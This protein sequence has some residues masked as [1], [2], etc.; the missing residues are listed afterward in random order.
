MNKN[1]PKVP[2]LTYNLALALNQQ[3]KMAESQT[4]L[5]HL[6][7]ENQWLSSKTP[8]SEYKQGD[9]KEPKPQ[10]SPSI[11]EEK[12]ALR[13]RIHLTQGLMYAAHLQFTNAIHA[14][15]KVS[16]EG[17]LSDQ[18]LFQYALASIQTGEFAI[19]IQALHTLTNKHTFNPRVYESYFAVGYLFEQMHKNTNAY[20]AYIK[21]SQYYAETTHTLE[22]ALAQSMD[23]YLQPLLTRKQP[24]NP[25]I[26]HLFAKESFQLNLHYIEELIALKQS[27]SLWAKKIDQFEGMIEARKIARN[28][29]I[30]H[31]QNKLYK[32]NVPAI[33]SRRDALAEAINEK[34]KSRDVYYFLNQE[35]KDNLA[36]I[37]KVKRNLNQY[38]NPNDTTDYATRLKHIEHF[39]YWQASEDFPIQRWEAEKNLH[40]LNRVLTELN[41]HTQ[42]LETLIAQSSQIVAL[43]QRIQQIKPRLQRLMAQTSMT[44]Q[45]VENQV[46]KQIKDE[47][48]AQLNNV[49]YFHAQSQLAQARLADQMLEAS[50]N[51]Q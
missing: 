35:Q 18:A 25:L 36:L 16:L 12:S 23:S 10:K 46:K 30:T 33:I 38:N 4:M 50:P 5:D 3:N 44:L 21:A 17:P 51:E 7:I 27:F 32:A 20:R 42:K 9:H 43:E 2:Y 1:A 11:E 19:A 8:Q 13:D 14:L 34:G 41:G 39:F 40:A 45:H 15:E 47:L 6:L 37:K 28:S 49:T 29:R 22:Q 26:S 31:T 24:P 48:T